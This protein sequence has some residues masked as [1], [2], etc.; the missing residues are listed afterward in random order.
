MF[1]GAVDRFGEQTRYSGFADAAWPREEVGMRNTPFGEGVAERLHN[2]FLADELV[3]GLRAVSAI[4]CLGGHGST[5]VA[6]YGFIIPQGVAVS[7]DLRVRM[8]GGGRYR[9]G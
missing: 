9:T 3:E 8:R 4:E 1:G 7:T 6:V 2:M 5:L